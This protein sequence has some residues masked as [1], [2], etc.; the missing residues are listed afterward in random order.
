MNQFKM[1]LL[2]QKHSWSTV[3]TAYFLGHLFFEMLSYFQVKTKQLAFSYSD[4]DNNP[5][6]NSELKF[7]LCFSHEVTE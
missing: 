1:R 2:L 5:T 3:T 7:N 6:D 4:P